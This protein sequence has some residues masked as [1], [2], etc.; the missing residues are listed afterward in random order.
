VSACVRVHLSSGH[1][2][3]TIPFDREERPLYVVPA[4]SWDLEGDDAVAARRWLRQPYLYY[5]GAH[6]GCGCGFD[7]SIYNQRMLED[8]GITVP[9]DPTGRSEK[10]NRACQRSAYELSDYLEG[11]VRLGDVEL[12]VFTHGE[13]SEPP[14]RP[15]IISPAYFRGSPNW[16]WSR[17]LCLEKGDFFIVHADGRIEG[18]G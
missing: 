6:F 15:R 11:A 16:I 18:A 12:L 8:A 7:F 1:P 10:F 14:K 13:G 3:P 9:S 2:L 5:A 17:Y 4:G